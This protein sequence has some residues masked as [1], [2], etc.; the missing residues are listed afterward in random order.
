MDNQIKLTITTDASGAVTGI[1]G[2]TTGMKKMES[3]TAGI[4]GGIKTSW[5]AVSAAATG[6]MIA[7]GKAWEYAQLGAGAIQ[8]EEAFAAVAKSADINAD[9]TIAAMKR[10][11]ANTIDDSALMQKALKGMTQGLSGEDMIKIAEIARVSART[12]GVSVEQAFEQITDSIANNTP[13]ALKRFG[14]VADEEMDKLSTGAKEGTKNVDLLAT[15]F[16]RTQKR[17]KQMGGAL[18]DSTS[19]WMQ[20]Q[21]ANLNELKESVGKILIGAGGMIGGALK[22]VGEAGGGVVVS[23]HRALYRLVGIDPDQVKKEIT[24]TN[25]ELSRLGDLDKVPKLTKVLELEDTKKGLEIIKAQIAAT[26]QGFAEMA[27]VIDKMGGMN[28]RFAGDDFKKSVSEQADDMRKLSVGYQNLSDTVKSGLDL[29][30]QIARVGD[31]TSAFT[32]FGGTVDSVYKNQISKQRDILDEMKNYETNQANIAKQAAT[33][34]QTEIKYNEEKLANY[35]SYYD[36]LKK[37]QKGYYDAALKATQDIANIEKAKVGDKKQTGDLLYS[38]WDKANPAA[39]EMEQYYRDASHLEQELNAAMTLSSEERVKTLSDIQR[40]YAGLSKQMTVGDTTF[41]TY[42]EVSKRIVAIGDAMAQAR[43]QMIADA[44]ATRDQALAAYAS[45]VEPIKAVETEIINVQ[46]T[47]INLD[48]LLA[49]Q[50]MLSIDVTGALSSL[51]MVRDQMNAVS[52][53][54]IGA[55]SAGS[56]LSDSNMGGTNWDGSPQVTYIDSYAS[57]INYVPRT[58]LYELH[59]GEKVTPAAENKSGASGSPVSISFGDIVIQGTNK[60][61]KQLAREIIGPIREELRKLEARK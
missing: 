25:K 3:E 40:Q 61:A 18:T 1:N 55:S 54:S 47:I 4:V 59:E 46:S 24:E 9:E 21:T 31:L 36:E 10:M 19:E 38:M 23:A 35:R 57:G 53:A 34:T 49:Q 8:A 42:D 41:N 13:R 60:D 22:S 51:R 37:L 33:V 5:L 20:Q 15:A 32:K 56:I 48:N 50:R 27:G 12:A 16:E 29:N 52:G 6:A 17:I 26:T 43:D 39:N 45:L 2:V 58:G 11:T 14:L 30:Q 28:L 44:A 7:I